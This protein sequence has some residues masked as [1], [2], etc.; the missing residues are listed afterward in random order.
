MVFLMMLV[1]SS[2]GNVLQPD[3]TVYVHEWGV[4]QMEDGIPM[5]LGAERGYLVENG[6]LEPYY[7]MTVDAPVLWFHGP[8]F[9]GTLTVEVQ[10]GYFSLLIPTPYAVS[11][12][13]ES[14]PVFQDEENYIAIWEDL[15]FGSEDI[16]VA[17]RRGSFDEGFQWAMPYWRE[18]PALIVTYEPA[19]YSDRFIYYECSASN[20]FAEHDPFENN[21]SGALLFSDD[22]GELRADVVS[23]PESS[24]VLV[25]DISDIMVMELLS[26]W[27][28]NEFLEEEIEA[29]WNTWEPSLLTKCVGYGQTVVLFPLTDEQIES[30]STLNLSVDQDYPVVYSRLFL[31]LDAHM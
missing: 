31:A 26:E 18:V 19:S 24:T 22:D 10:N 12:C 29:L 11:T 16:L 6:M 8:E 25:S 1:L 30:I 4:V 17:D 13:D 9:T 28:D 3:E 5:A 27:G 23:G 14:I 15:R 20:L 2:A 21:Q 7:S